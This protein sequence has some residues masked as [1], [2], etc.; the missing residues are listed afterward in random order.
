ML[1]KK[2]WIGSRAYVG[3]GVRIGENAIVGATASV[4]KNVEANTI[5]GGNPAK[6]LKLRIEAA[7]PDIQ[8]Q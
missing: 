6:I 3:L 4:Y 5:V 1:E 7:L 8:Q 2:S